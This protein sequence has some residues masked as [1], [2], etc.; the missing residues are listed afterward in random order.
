MAL[1]HDPCI[2]SRDSV[3]LL[4]HRSPNFITY[5]HWLP[6][7]E[8]YSDDPESKGGRSPRLGFSGRMNPPW[9]PRR[10]LRGDPGMRG[11]ASEE[12]RPCLIRACAVMGV[13]LDPMG[14]DLMGAARPSPVYPKL[15]PS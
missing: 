12:L 5:P 13:P 2:E 15:A 9:C 6:K 1:S 8:L 3:P 11:S 4:K 14:G 10:A 7:P